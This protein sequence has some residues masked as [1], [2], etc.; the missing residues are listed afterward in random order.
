MLIALL[1]LNASALE[2]ATDTPSF[3]SFYIVDPQHAQSEKEVA[4]TLEHYASILDAQE[5][6][7]LRLLSTR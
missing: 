3:P 5:Y 4:L 6:Q 1:M 2:K 7:Q